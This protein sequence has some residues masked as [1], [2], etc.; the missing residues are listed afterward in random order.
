[1]NEEVSVADLDTLTD[2]YERLL[3]KLLA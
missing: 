2:V 3:E 1:V